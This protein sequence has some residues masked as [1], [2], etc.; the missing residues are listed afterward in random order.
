[1]QEGSGQ[2]LTTL[3]TAAGHG[4]GDAAARLFPLIYDKLRHLAQRY[5]AR[6]K[7]GHTLQPTALVHEA[8]LR[9]FGDQEVEWKSRAH[10]LGAAAQAMRRILVERARKYRRLKHGGG[11]DRVLLDL[12]GLSNDGSPERILELDEALQRLEAM[13]KRKCDVVM[14]RYFTGLSIQETARALGISATTVKLE[15]TFSRAWLAAELG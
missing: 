14:L 11:R 6:E 7:A 12:A 1:M 13:D 9:L 15:W 2:D 10:F 4:D 5:M 3:L 8:Y